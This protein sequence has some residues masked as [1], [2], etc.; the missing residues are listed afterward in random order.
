MRPK[1]ISKLKWNPCKISYEF[2]LKYYLKICGEPDHLALDT[3][4]EE[5][6]NIDNVKCT[7][8][9]K[10]KIT[11]YLLDLVILK[12]LCTLGNEVPLDI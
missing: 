5:T 11:W 1:E 3:K 7:I 12:S 4:E 2:L 8:H 9:L 6:L 10:V